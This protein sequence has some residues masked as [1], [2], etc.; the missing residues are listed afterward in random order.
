MFSSNNQNL[1][2]FISLITSIV[3]TIAFASQ[4]ETN[5]RA[6]FSSMPLD[7]ETVEADSIASMQNIFRTRHFSW[8]PKANPQKF[9]LLKKLPESLSTIKS[10]KKKKQLFIQA[11]LPIAQIENH[12]ILQQR[13]LAFL[14]TK[15]GHLPRDPQLLDELANLKK[16][17]R[18]KTNNPDNLRHLLLQRIDILPEAL[19]IAQAAI[20]SGWGS[21]RFAL[22]GNSLFGQWTFKEGSGI[23]PD[24]RQEG[25]THQVRA[26]PNLRASVRSY[27]Q[28]INTNNAYRE[29]RNLRAVLR[30][31]NHALDPMKLSEGLH[32]YSQRKHEYVDEIKRILRSKEFQAIIG[33]S[34]YSS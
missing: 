29:L 18:V 4:V 33:F 9:I 24:D 20:E 12:R 15:D 27:L 7:V 26:F 19:I 1:L 23:V 13:R 25:L 10:R 2:G 22:E 11:L 8:P 21:S 17:Y 34:H 6:T 32:R 28:N 5:P 3:T 31:K 30:N 16:Q 14:L